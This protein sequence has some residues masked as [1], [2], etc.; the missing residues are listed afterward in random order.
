M[1][2]YDSCYTFDT[3]WLFYFFCKYYNHDSLNYNWRPKFNSCSFRKGYGQRNIHETVNK[4]A[5]TVR[6]FI[7]KYSHEN[8]IEKLGVAQKKIQKT[9][10]KGRLWEKCKITPRKVSPN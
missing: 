1:T 6:H 7:E 5:S 4:Y 2:T 3:L 9:W 8:N 10:R